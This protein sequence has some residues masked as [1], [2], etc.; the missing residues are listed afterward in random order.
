MNTSTNPSGQP[1]NN[2][3][4]DEGGEAGRGGERGGNEENEGNEGMK[5]AKY[6]EGAREN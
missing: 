6:V 4:P 1:H 3:H 5:S 2:T